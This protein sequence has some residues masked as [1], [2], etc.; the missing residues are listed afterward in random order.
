M[1]RAE[2]AYANESITCDETLSNKNRPHVNL[3]Y[4]LCKSHISALSLYIL[5]HHRNSLDR[6]KLDIQRLEREIIQGRIVE[7]ERGKTTNPNIQ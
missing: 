5:K 2:D 7:L 6:L 1:D 3:T 4:R